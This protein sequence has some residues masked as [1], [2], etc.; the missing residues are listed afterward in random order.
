MRFLKSGLTEENQPAI[1][2]LGHIFGS[3]A[4]EHVDIFLFLG[5][6]EAINNLM[7]EQ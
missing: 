7:T 6:L 4:P 3:N 1:K 2:T 5:A